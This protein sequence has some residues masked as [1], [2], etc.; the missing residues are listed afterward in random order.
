MIEQ[1]FA[2]ENT[3][4][5]VALMIMVLLGFIEGIGMVIGMGVSD[6]ID[7]MLPDMDVDADLDVDVDAD[8][9][10]SPD[11]GL[12]SDHGVE[13]GQVDHIGPFTRMLSWL[14]IGRVPILILAVIFLLAFGLGGLLLQ[15]LV[16]GIVGV[17]LPTWVAVVPALFFGVGSMNVLGGLAEKIV[18][19][20]ESSAVSHDSFVGRVATITVG[21]ARTGSSAEARLRDQHQ[22]AHYVM[23][24]PDVE[25]E[26]LHQGEDVLIVR[27]QG[28]VF[29]AISNPNSAL[30]DEAE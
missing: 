21:T 22:Q 28:T 30:V 18:P 19:R 4:F 17:P 25:G 29:M 27:K 2:P 3:P 10:A 15:S 23:I 7:G 24:E 9:D 11:G 6:V 1:F 26:K 5:A 13:I 12:S 20:D 14:R 16:S 8:L